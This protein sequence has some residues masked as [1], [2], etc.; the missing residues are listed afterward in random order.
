MKKIF[1]LLILILI[2]CN[3][4]FSQNRDKEIFD[5]FISLSYKEIKDT[6]EIPTFVSHIDEEENWQISYSLERM[7]HRIN[8]PYDEKYDPIFIST[9]LRDFKIFNYYREVT[10]IMKG[11]YCMDWNAAR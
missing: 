8:R 5:S 4:T 6:L 1:I 2:N 3:S 7:H 10:F 9:A 11:D